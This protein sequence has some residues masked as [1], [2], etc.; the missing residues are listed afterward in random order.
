MMEQCLGSLRNMLDA[1]NGLC[2]EGK[3]HKRVLFVIES[4]YEGT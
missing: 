1:C 4:S 2:C 3:K